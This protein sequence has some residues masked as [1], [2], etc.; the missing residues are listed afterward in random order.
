M[1]GVIQACLDLTDW[2][3]FEAAATNLDELTETVTSYIS[4]CEDICI[5]TRTDVTFNNDKSWFTAKLN[6]LIRP[7]RMPK[8]MGTESCTIRPGTHWIR[9]FEWLKGPTLKSWKISSLPITPLQCG[10]ARKPSPSTGH[11]PPARRRINNLLKNWMSFIVDLKPPKPVLTI[12]LHN[13][14]APPATPLSPTPVLQISEED[15]RQ[16]FRKNKRR[17]VPGPDGVTPACLKTCADQ[18]A[19]IFTQIFNRSLELC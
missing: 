5:S 1:I 9:R 3:D 4:Y 17:K 11:H 6:T 18:L 14:L 19:P 12:S 2:S 13:M 10:K 7:K 8:E 16:V 15:V